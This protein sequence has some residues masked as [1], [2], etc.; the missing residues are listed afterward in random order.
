MKT[1]LQLTAA[2]LISTS[3]SLFLFLFIKTSPKEVITEVTTPVLP[4]T[5]AYNL[6]GL[7][8][9]LVIL[10]RRPTKVLV[11]WYMSKIPLFQTSV[12]LP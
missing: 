10:S 4:T 12:F 9:P 8:E 5:Y 2:V 3:L 6:N 7:S 11:P 1:I